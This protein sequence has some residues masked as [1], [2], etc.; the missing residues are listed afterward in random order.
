MSEKEMSG[1]EMSGEEMGRGKNVGEEMAQE[2][3]PQIFFI[4]LVSM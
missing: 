1:E 4:C 3:L 2:K